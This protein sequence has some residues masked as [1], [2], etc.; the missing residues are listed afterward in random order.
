MKRLLKYSVCSILMII[1]ANNLYAQGESAVPFLLI[2]PDARPG[3]MGET[4]VAMAENATAIWWNPAGLAFQYED[5]ETDKKGEAS[6]MHVK[7][8]P[9]F[10]FSDLWYDYLAARYY[11][12]GIGMLGASITFLNLG[13]NHATDENGNDLGTFDSKEYAL[14]VSYATKIKENLGIGVNLKFIKS[15]LTDKNLQ[16][17]SENRDGRSSSFAIDLGVKWIPAYEFLGNRLSLGANLA[18]F[19][20]KMTYIDEN[21]ADPLPTNL[22]FGIAYKLLDDEFN[23]INL[24]YD[25]NKLLVNR[26]GNSS[27]NV[28]KAVFYSAWTQDIRK[29]THSVGM[30]YWYGNLIALRAGYF[31]EDNKYGGRQFMTFGA[32]LKYYVFGIDFGY[33]SASEDHPLSDTMRFSLLVQF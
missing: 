17:G 27:D 5:S 8:L 12:D 16:V 7:W 6:L 30:E 22:R 24:V 10:N 28:F 25:A 4:G 19:G 32:G 21:Q 3:G 33:I 14:T 29:I 2:A 9:Q 11:I 1:A 31:Y 13:T 23:Q 15:D 26:D 18:N 20:P